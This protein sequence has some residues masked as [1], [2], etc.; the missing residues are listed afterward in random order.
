MLGLATE[1]DGVE[2]QLVIPKNRIETIAEWRMV[3]IIAI[4]I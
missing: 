3:F 1:G 2:E 4:K